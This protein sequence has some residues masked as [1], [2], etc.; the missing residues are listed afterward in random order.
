MI[1]P[2]PWDETTIVVAY[3]D[4]GW[5][6][7]PALKSQTGCLIAITTV[8]ALTKTAPASY[9]DHQ[10][11]RTHRTVR[12]T[13]AAESIAAD[14]AVDRGTYVAAYL[15]EVITGTSAIS[16]ACSSKMLSSSTPTSQRNKKGKGKLNRD[17]IPLYLV[18]DCKSLYDVVISEAP[19]LSEKRTLIDIL[20]IQNWISPSRIHVGSH[21][22]HDRRCANQEGSQT[23]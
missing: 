7:A 15:S 8:D 1:N 2:I 16:F 19:T 20:S 23:S 14:N 4:S 22:S 13:L 18:T 11:Q 6:N 12:S 9:A 3:G 21:R 17:I 5:A 10:S